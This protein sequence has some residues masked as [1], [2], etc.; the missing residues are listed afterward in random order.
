MNSSIIDNKFSL[1]KRHLNFEK[2]LIINYPLSD[3]APDIKSLTY[4]NIRYGIKRLNLGGRK[5]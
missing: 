4:L 3:P 5:D 1:K 2:S